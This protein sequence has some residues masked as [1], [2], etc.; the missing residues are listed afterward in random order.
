M[1]RKVENQRITTFPFA[2]FLFFETR[3][4]KDIFEKDLWQRR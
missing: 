2:A 3:P 1:T 4:S